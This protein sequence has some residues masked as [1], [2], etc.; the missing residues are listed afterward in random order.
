M[1]CFTTLGSHLIPLLAIVLTAV[2][3]CIGVTLN[4]CPKAMFHS[5]T[6]P[7]LLSA[8]NIPFASPGSAIP[9]FSSNP[10]RSK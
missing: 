5:S 2:M 9:V 3:S 1:L 6:G 10:K 7:T 4:L 8:K